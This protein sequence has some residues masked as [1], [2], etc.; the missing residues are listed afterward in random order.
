M[1]DILEQSEVA[2]EISNALSMPCG[3]ED[4][5]EVSRHLVI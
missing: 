4:I 2:H 3:S 5:D 1:D